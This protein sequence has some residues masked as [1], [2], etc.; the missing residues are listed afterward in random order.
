MS[1]TGEIFRFRIVG[2]AMGN[3]SLKSKKWNLFEAWLATRGHV[4]ANSALCK[5]VSSEEAA[6]PQRPQPD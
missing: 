6:F 1:T 5:N 4:H 2:A 3:S